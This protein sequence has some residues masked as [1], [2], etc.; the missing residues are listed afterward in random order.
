MNHSVI[1]LVCAFVYIGGALVYACI[2]ADEFNKPLADE[3]NEHSETVE[4]V[5]VGK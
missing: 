4:V 5:E 2:F 3:F 1:A